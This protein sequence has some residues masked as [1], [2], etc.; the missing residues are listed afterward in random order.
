MKLEIKKPFKCYIGTE[1]R[2]YYPGDKT[3]V[4]VE[5]GIRKTTGII[6]KPD[7]EEIETLVDRYEVAVPVIEKKAPDASGKDTD[8]N[9][10]NDKSPGKDTDNKGKPGKPGK[11][12]R[13]SKGKK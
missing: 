13:P 9:S 6:E 5:R 7:M 11:P 4:K 8:K 2:E 3:I 12:G 1:L 10:N